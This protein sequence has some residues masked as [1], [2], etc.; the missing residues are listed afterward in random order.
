MKFIQLAMAGLAA[1][2]AQQA[3]DGKTLDSSL[4]L[5]EDNLEIDYEYDDDQLFQIEN[6]DDYYEDA[7]S[8]EFAPKD[9]SS[10]KRL[11][12]HHASNYANNYASNC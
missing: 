12:T 3:T 1:A 11:L 10:S 2:Q 7:A 4:D 9:G 8:Q 6:D 5:A